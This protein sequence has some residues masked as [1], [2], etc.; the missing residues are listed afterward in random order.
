MTR[1]G[2]GT[3][4][5]LLSSCIHGSIGECNRFP[6]N[7]KKWTTGDGPNG[8]FEQYGKYSNIK[9]GGWIYKFCVA[10]SNI[11]QHLI[12]KRKTWQNGLGTLLITKVGHNNGCGGKDGTYKRHHVKIGSN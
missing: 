1:G 7:Q 3:G 4:A 11:E 10:C 12:Q 6:C 9:S 2:Y 5:P 8:L